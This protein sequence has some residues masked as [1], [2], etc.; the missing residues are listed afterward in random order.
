[1]EPPDLHDGGVTHALA[2]GGRIL[3]VIVVEAGRRYISKI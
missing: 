2:A 3:L 1:M